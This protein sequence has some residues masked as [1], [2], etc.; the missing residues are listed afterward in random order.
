[1]TLKE[2]PCFSVH[3]KLFLPSRRRVSSFLSQRKFCFSSSVTISAPAD[4]S[5]IEPFLVTETSPFS[6]LWRWPLIADPGK[7]QFKPS[8]ILRRFRVISSIFITPSFLSLLFRTFHLG[9]YFVSTAKPST[10]PCPSAFFPIVTLF[11]FLWVGV[12]FRP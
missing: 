6:Y 3:V 1:M 7:M 11:F 8:H 12:L 10:S 9:V 5:I 2:T 4:P